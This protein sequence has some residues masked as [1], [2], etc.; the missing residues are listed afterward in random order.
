MNI[1]TIDTGT[2]NTRVSVWQHGAVIGQAARQVGVRD[3]AITG[4]RTRLE[5]GVR[6]TIAEALATAELGEGDI[7]RALASGM[8]HGR[9]TG[10]F[11]RASA[12]EQNVLAAALPEGAGTTLPRNA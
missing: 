3:T 11:D 12:N 5:E 2:T 6:E 1:L 8:C 9:I 10:Q 4:S 7:D